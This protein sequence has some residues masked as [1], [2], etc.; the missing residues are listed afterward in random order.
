MLIGVKDYRLAFDLV[1]NRQDLL[2]EVT[3][4]NGCCRTLMA[5]ER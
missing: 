5:L 1:F 2:L 3:G 4:G